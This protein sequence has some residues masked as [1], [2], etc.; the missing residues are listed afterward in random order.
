[1]LKKPKKKKQIAY[2]DRICRSSRLEKG[3][4]TDKHLDSPCR[5]AREGRRCQAP[6]HQAA[7]DQEPLIPPAPPYPQDQ[8]EEGLLRHSPFDFRLNLWFLSGEVVVDVGELGMG[9]MD[10]DGKA[11]LKRGRKRE[12]WS[13]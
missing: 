4:R 6:L 9:T 1:M 3:K 12:R 10:D 7:P 8:Q 13:K 11:L 5:R 2:N